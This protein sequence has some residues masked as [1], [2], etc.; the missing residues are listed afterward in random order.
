MATIQDVATRAGVAPITVSRVLNHSGYV[1]E[2]TRQRVEAAAAEL[3]YVPN[4]LA[5]G[6]RSNRTNTLALVLTD[7]TNPFWTTVARGVEDAARARGFSVILCNTDEN[8]AKQ[9]QYVDVLIRKR[10]DGFLLAPARSTPDPIHKIQ[11]QANAPVVVLDRR[12]AGAEVDLVCGDSYGGSYALTRYLLDLGHRHIGVLSGPQ[13]VSTAAERVAGHKA[14]LQ[15][16]GLDVYSNLIQYGEYTVESGYCMMQQ[17]LDAAPYPTA[18]FAT[19]NFIAIGALQQLREAGLRVP[20]D[21]SLVGFDDLPM[22]WNTEPFLTVAVQPAYEI[23]QQAA[24]LLI[25]RISQQDT[26]EPREF[27]L[28]TELVIRQSCRANG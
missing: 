24:N 10:M 17:V 28:P 1:S 8:E 27:I 12:I 23:G 25:D 15:E 14:A 26:S 16:A 9:A 18:I 7:I 6:L 2:A 5:R 3:D 13:T 19:N 21:I 11:K 22:S 4:L 20:A